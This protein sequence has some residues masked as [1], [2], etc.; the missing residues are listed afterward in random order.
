[1]EK[2]AAYQ[3]ITLLALRLQIGSFPCRSPKKGMIILQIDNLVVE[4]RILFSMC[5]LISFVHNQ[6]PDKD[7]RA[8]QL[9]DPSFPRSLLVTKAFD[10]VQCY[11]Q[12]VLINFI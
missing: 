10:V 3:N 4:H 12:L 8:L 7:S 6:G 9:H 1:M 2:N 5:I 11:S